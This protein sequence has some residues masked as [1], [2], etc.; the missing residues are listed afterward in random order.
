MIPYELGKTE[1]GRDMLVQDYILKQLTAS[2]IYPEKELGKKFWDNVYAK[3]RQMYGVTDIPVN[4]FN[5]VWIVADKAKVLERNNAAYIVGSHLKVMLEEDYLAFEKNKKGLSSP[6]SSVGDPDGDSSSGFPTKAFGNDKGVNNLGS[7]IVRQV[8]LPELEKEVN[9]GQNFAPLRQMFYSMILASWYKIALKDALLNQVYSNKGK[10]GGVLS[11]DPAVKQ[12]IYEQYLKAYK[13][14]VFNYIKEDMDA[15]SKQ[16][17][18]RKYFSGGEKMRL[19][20]GENLTI[21]HEQSRDDALL[22]D[23]DL[24]M[25]SVKVA[26]KSGADVAML[27]NI[28][29]FKV[30][31]QEATTQE[32]LKRVYRKM[33]Q[34]FHP[35]KVSVEDKEA[36]GKIFIELKDLIEQQLSNVFNIKKPE[37]DTTKPKTAKEGDWIDTWASEYSNAEDAIDA[38]KR[39]ARL[40]Q[41]RGSE[42]IELV[43]NLVSNKIDTLSIQDLFDLL[44]TVSKPEFAK[45]FLG[46]TAKGAIAPVFVTD[47]MIWQARP[48]I[49]KIYAARTLI[50]GEIVHFRKGTQIIRTM[51]LEPITKIN[52]DLKVITVS[53]EKYQIIN[54]SQQQLIGPNF[55]FER[56]PLQRGYPLNIGDMVEVDLSD[57][58]KFIVRRAVATITSVGGGF[59]TMVGQNKV[60]R[61]NDFLA[62]YGFIWPMY[63]DALGLSSGKIRKIT[64]KTLRLEEQSAERPKFSDGN[65]REL[66]EPAK[67]EIIVDTKDTVGKKTLQALMSVDG[68]DLEIKIEK[69]FWEGRPGM[70]FTTVTFVRRVNHGTNVQTWIRRPIDEHPAETAELVV[71]LIK[72]HQE[73]DVENGYYSL[74][75]MINTLSVV[76][77]KK[78][79]EAMKA[80]EAF[81]GGIDLNAKNMSLDVSGQGIDMKFD[82][83]MVAEFQK[84][85]F[86]GVEGIILRIVPIQSPLSLFGLEPQKAGRALGRGVI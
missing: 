21:A 54:I 12:K 22:K 76:G 69:D 75:R 17:V 25:A 52:S 43:T 51:I 1:L 2:L 49:E 44:D 77:G 28:E 81:P 13:K 39:R 71:D 58:P 46:F 4:T 37:K 29:D 73:F 82:P 36:A 27:A 67:Q 64:E 59:F 6:K 78:A 5:K 8:I 48:M 47:D 72:R 10:T 14:G 11:D 86:T 9:Q 84:G 80:N 55:D 85:N 83:A 40:I 31:I 32:E 74:P 24:A 70:V 30:L 60:H 50:K 15:V 34:A 33:A 57:N 56:E 66:T 23:G 62:G 16:P 20:L 26:G 38:L 45:K 79:D 41:D 61:N 19:R 65:Q 68:Q 63:N 35:D 7:Q 18:P 53:D 42:G 3:A